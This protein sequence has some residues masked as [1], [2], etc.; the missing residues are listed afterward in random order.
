LKRF[1]TGVAVGKFHPPHK[2]H[3]FLIETARA[4]CEHLTVLVAHRPDQL[5]PVELRVACLAEVHPGLDVRAVPDV[6]PAD[7]SVGWAEYT[8]R[9][10]GGRPEA[11]FTSEDYG[12]AYARAMGATH[13]MVDRERGR[14]P[15]SGT[16][17]RE[18]PLGNLEWL[19]P[20]MRA[21]YVRRVCV[22]DAEST[23]TTTLAAAL[24][25]HYGTVWVPEYG[26]EYCAAKWK[27]GYTTDWETAEFLAIA[28]EQARRE[29]LAAR[30][31]NRL[32][33][34]DTD[35]FATVLW[36]ERYLGRRS[37]ELEALAATRRCHLYLLTG[38]EIPFVQDGLRDGERVR[39]EMH[40]AFVR[41][42]E[43]TGRPFLLLRGPHELRLR[44]AVEQVEALL[45]APA[46]PRDYA[47]QRNESRA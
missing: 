28:R 4:Q 47:P 7:D 8:C 40:Q 2:G 36:H 9:L 42:L 12:D 15:C 24:G 27:D 3:H 34:C 5:L 21:V 23:G 37:S 44:T 43:T 41:E 20:F 38:D 6:V 16:R 30:S 26:R 13:V 18:D 17:I 22:L 33:V 19:S 32:L 31:A 10:L 35:V 39:S 11:A 46:L 45:A 25:E 1:R 29:D 14:V